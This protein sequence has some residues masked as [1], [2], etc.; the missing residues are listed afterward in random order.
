MNIPISVRLDKLWDGEFCKNDWGSVNY[1]V[2][3]NGTGKSLLAEQLKNAFSSNG[4][5]VRLLSAERLSGFEKSDYSYFSSSGFSSGLNISQFADFKRF[6]ENYGLST[7]GFI[8]LKERLDIRIRIEALLSDIF[9]KRIR[10]VEEGGFLKPKIQNLYRGAEYNLKES[11]CHG[12]KE[13]I[14]LLAFLFDPTNNLIIF[15]EPELH[16]HPQFQSFFMK[17]LQNIA[18][19]PNST[20]TKKIFII[21]THSP[22]F[23]DCRTLDDL[24]NIIVTHYNRQPTFIDSFD[25]QDEYTLKRF[26]PRFNTHHKQFFFSP[27]PVFVEGYTDQQLISLLFEKIGIN[28]GSSGSC[29]VDVGGKDELAV[30]FRLTNKLQLDS[31]VIA[32]FDAIFRGKLREVVQSN[33][34]CIEYFISEGYGRDISASIGEIERKI[35]IIANEIYNSDKVEIEIIPLQNILKIIIAKADSKNDVFDLTLLTLLRY[36]EQMKG[37]LSAGLRLSPDID[38]VFARYY[39]LISVLKKCNVFIIPHGE[40]E[41]YF[42]HSEI[43]YLSYGR[44]DEL[45][46]NEFDFLLG[47]TEANDIETLYSDLLAAISHAIPTIKIDLKEHMKFQIVEWI[48]C[49]Q[50]AIA[51]KEVYDIAS[52]KANVNIDYKLFNQLFDIPDDG[53][54]ITK[55]LKFTCKMIINRASFKTQKQNDFFRMTGSLK[56]R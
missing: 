50:R 15:D 23:I 2:G 35:H 36:K 39:I 52:L 48:Q 38:F 25:Q 33:E 56:V 9:K 42:K 32:D 19:D 13:L 17:E 20:S 40:M 37:S 49:V 31:R 44:K 14:T 24:K 10:L 21:I 11:E 45:F 54:T 53:L 51:K 5:R 43:N 3:S 30:F 18:G 4:Y 26:L 1:I 47:L 55:D 29:I 46:H 12:L 28:I 6:G 22:Y 27:N 34:K 8:I 16:L 41:H 7:S